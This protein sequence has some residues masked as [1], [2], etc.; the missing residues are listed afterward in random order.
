[1]RNVLIALVIAALATLAQAQ[2]ATATVGTPFSATIAAPVTNGGYLVTINGV[3]ETSVAG[4]SYNN[5]TGVLSGTP[6]TA[7]TYNIEVQQAT[8]TA[9]VYTTTKL[10]LTVNAAG[11]TPPVTPPVTPPSTLFCATDTNPACGVV[12]TWVAPPAATTTAL[13]VTG[14][15]VFRSTSSTAA[16]QITAA[17]IT[18]V[19]YTDKTI[20]PSTT[21]DYYVVSVDAAGAQSAPSNTLQV[22]VAAAPSV[23]TPATPTN[24]TGSVVN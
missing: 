18:A 6:T 11:T 16:V 2:T 8:A 15:L 14:Y 10:T 17:P 1:M 24:L 7:G 9:G 20:A 4:L 12:L 22:I 13:A 3:Q 19:T 21:Y 5:T 23:P